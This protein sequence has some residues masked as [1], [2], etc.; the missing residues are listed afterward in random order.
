MINCLL[1]NP[2]LIAVIQ[3]LLMWTDWLLTLAQ[4][5]EVKKYY[6]KHYKSY[7]TNT[8]EGNPL[9]QSDVR[10]EKVFNIKHFTT[11]IIIGAIVFFSFKFL[12]KESQEFFIGIVF[13]VYLLVNTQHLSNL[14]GYRAS[15]KGVHGQLYIHLKTGYLVQA[16]RYFSTTVL[17][18][19][20]SILSES[21]FIYGMTIASFM[22]VLRHF[23]WMKKIAP[24]KPEDETFFEK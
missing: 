2:L 16:G 13:G 11:S 1:N 14:L 19:V 4:A 10:N 8:I 24:I 15:R 18:L 3:I 22:S 9:L 17:L 6:S 7:P 5:R 23:I 12:P 20:L 21:Q